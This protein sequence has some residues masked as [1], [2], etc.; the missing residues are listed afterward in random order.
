M[1]LSK[2]RKMWG[3]LGN[4]GLDLGHLTL[5]RSTPP[6]LL[7]GLPWSTP[8]PPMLFPLLAHDK[9][10]LPYYQCYQMLQETLVC[11]PC[12]CWFEMSTQK[13]NLSCAGKSLRISVSFGCSWRPWDCVRNMCSSK[14]NMN[15]EPDIFVP[16][17]NPIWCGFTFRLSILFSFVLCNPVATASIYIVD[18]KMGLIGTDGA[19]ETLWPVSSFD[20]TLISADLTN[21]LWE[22]NFVCVFLWFL[23]SCWSIWPSR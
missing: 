3:S 13:Y 9:T 6:F 23:S 21:A 18:R 14:A 7:P 19:Q 8:K 11:M 20:T 5:L 15:E 1:V 16:C 10:P 12:Y 4:W 22:L 2:K 17:T